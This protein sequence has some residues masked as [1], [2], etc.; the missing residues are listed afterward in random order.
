MDHV[1][2]R[3]AAVAVD[4]IAGVEYTVL[5]HVDDH[6]IAM[7]NAGEVAGQVLEYGAVQFERT[8]HRE[9]VLLN[10]R[11]AKRDGQC[12]VSGQVNQGRIG[13][14]AAGALCF[15]HVYIRRHIDD[16]RVTCRIQREFDCGILVE[17]LDVLEMRVL[18]ERVAREFGR[19]DLTLRIR[20]A[21]QR[22]ER[23]DIIKGHIAIVVR[24]TVD[25]GARPR[26]T[27]RVAVGTTE[28]RDERIDV[29]KIND[30]VAVHVPRSVA[31]RQPGHEQRGE[32][33]Y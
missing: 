17:R 13:I 28:G 22:H 9:R 32:Q 14:P 11:S 19:H 27:V 29:V 2:A 7:A 21:D 10:R 23:I 4:V 8:N 3:L 30:P 16:V 6:V 15:D 31:I 20:G 26:P 25:P 12:P 5:V 18:A 1:Q 33:G 24:V